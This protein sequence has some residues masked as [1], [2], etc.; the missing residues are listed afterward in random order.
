M[1][2]L[3]QGKALRLVFGETITELAET[4]GGTLTLISSA[5]I[6]FPQSNAGCDVSPISRASIAPTVPLRG[7]GT[8]RTTS[9]SPSSSGRSTTRGSR[10]SATPIGSTGAS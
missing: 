7:A 1:T 8:S 4:A 6:P 9:A 10:P 2:T 5:L 3:T